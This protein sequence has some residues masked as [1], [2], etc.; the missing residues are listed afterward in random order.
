M[1]LLMLLLL[2][3]LTAERRLRRRAEASIPVQLPLRFW[4]EQP[5]VALPAVA[6]AEA[7]LTACA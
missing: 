5:P 6:C 7:V 3:L 4:R 1:L 2:P